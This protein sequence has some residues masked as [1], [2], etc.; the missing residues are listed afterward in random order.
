[1]ISSHVKAEKYYAVSIKTDEI[2]KLEPAEAYKISCMQTFKINK[3]GR[4]IH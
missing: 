4:K 3:N 2:N 1:M